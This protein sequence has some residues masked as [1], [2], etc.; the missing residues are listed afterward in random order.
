[1]CQECE[2]Q[3]LDR[4]QL[5]RLAG[6]GLT[7]AALLAAAGRP[8]AAASSASQ[9]AAVPVTPAEALARLKEGNLRFVKD[10]QSCA[11]DLSALRGQLAGGQHPWATILTCSDSR[12]SPELVFGGST[13]G[14]LFVIRN[15]GNVLDTGALGTIEYGAE[16]LKSPLVVVMGHSNCGAVTAACDE[17]TKGSEIGGSIGKMLQPILP[18]ALAARE[19]AQ[20]FV[21]ETVR[22]NAI[23]GARRITEE[24]DILRELVGSGNVMVVA[25]VYDITSGL[26]D[27]IEAI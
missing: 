11:A 24:S 20:D 5:F 22:Q 19:G 27:F 17:V 1:M 10:A 16:H 8:A 18:V 21:A 6:G 26:V 2:T 23:S 3:G 4:R 14:D 12:V 13:L 9:W 7:V 15:A 25:G